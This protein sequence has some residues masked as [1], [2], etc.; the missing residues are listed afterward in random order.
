[1]RGASHV[2]AVDV[3]RR[4]LLTVR[5]NAKLNGVSVTTTRGDLFDAVG[6]ACF[7]LIVS[8]PPYLPSPD[9]RI[10][11]RGPARAWDAGLRGRVFLDRICAEAP[12]HLSPNGT[13]LLTHSSVCGEQETLATLTAH[14]LAVTVAERKR[15]PLGERLGARAQWLR[16]RG[17]LTPDGL[18][19]I[20][21][22]RAQ[23]DPNGSIPAVANHSPALPARA[24]VHPLA[25]SNRAA[26]D[27]ELLG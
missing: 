23:R 22:I 26:V 19:D 8:N 16:D 13:L 3:S 17:L 11:T 10:P 21:I 18:E 14:G 6:D 15:G 12:A 5:L 27:R 9:P 4:A 25:G 20:L 1:M 2:V 7:D 24:Q